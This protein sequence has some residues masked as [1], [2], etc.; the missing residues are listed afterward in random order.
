MMALQVS[1]SSQEI[2]NEEEDLDKSLSTEIE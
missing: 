1:G 2:F